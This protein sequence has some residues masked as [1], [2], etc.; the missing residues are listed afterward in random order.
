MGARICPRICMPHSPCLSLH[1]PSPVPS[2][3]PLLHIVDS[4]LPPSRYL[5]SILRVVNVTS[6]SEM[7][8][9]QAWSPLDV[10]KPFNYGYVMTKYREET[11]AINNTEIEEY[12]AQNVILKTLFRV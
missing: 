12:G 10:T 11:F 4:S 8:L 1:A 2:L 9:L 5:R 3:R 7:E 6:K